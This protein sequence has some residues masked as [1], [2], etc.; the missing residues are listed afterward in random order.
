MTVEEKTRKSRPIWMKKGSYKYLLELLHG[1]K[2]DLT[3][4]RN[5]QRIIAKGME[6]YFVFDKSYIDDIACRDEVDQAI[7]EMLKASPASGILP[8]D[9]AREIQHFEVTPWQ[10]TLRIR[11]MNKRLVKQ[12]GQKVAEKRGLHWALTSFAETASERT[13]EEISKETPEE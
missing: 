5:T 12:I 8:R 2:R 9:I 10:V 6:R 4:I 1:I 3:D 11:R 13:R 7:L